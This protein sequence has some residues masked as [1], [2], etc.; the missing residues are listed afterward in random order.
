[1]EAISQN[2]LNILLKGKT[3]EKEKGKCTET[4]MIKTNVPGTE[5]GKKREM[6]RCGGRRKE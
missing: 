5:V 3:V 6:M 4:W 1:M 2:G